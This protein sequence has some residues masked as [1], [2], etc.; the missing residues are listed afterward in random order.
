MTQTS[1][2]SRKK[3]SEDRGDSLRIAAIDVGS[4]SVHMIVA[5][6]DADGGVTTL[7]RMKEMVGLGRISFPSRRLSAEAM[8]RAVDTLSRFNQA[9]LQRGAERIVI[10]ATSA[11]REA[12]NGGDL[13]QRIRR[14]LKLYV[15][16]VTAR[17][18]ARLIYLGVRHAIDLGKQPTLLIDIGGGSVEFIVGNAV[19]ASLLESRKLGA[20]RITSRFVKSDPIDKSDRK[21]LRAH[22]HAELD[23]LFDQI[24][25]LKPVRVIGTS[26]TFENL[27]QLCGDTDDDGNPVVGRKSFSRV[28]KQL[29]ASD[30]SK[31]EKIPGLDSHR[32]EQIVAASLLIDFMMDE[33]KIDRIELA[34]AALREGILIDYL[35]RHMP[36]VQIRSEVSDPRRRSVIDLAR[37]CHWHEKHSIQVAHLT[38]RLFDQLHDLHRLGK[39]ERELIEYAALLHDIGWHIAPEG[40]HKHSMY[41]ILNSDLRKHFDAEELGIIANIARYHRKRPPTV[42]HES[43]ARLSKSGRRVVDVGAA[44][45]RVA[46]GMDRSHTSV[47]LDLKT[48]IDDDDGVVCR[49]DVRADAELEMWGAKR[50]SGYFEE[51]F[52]RAIDFEMKA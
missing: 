14:E 7:W 44:L 12:F 32:K 19:D 21:A 40:H 49:M 35:S 4:N 28:L 17:D 46:D 37:R 52:G 11:V 39:D 9:A 25:S 33:L 15:K 2:A 13:I 31:R 26:G 3:S 16:V 5:Q 24:R 6:I 1:A 27:A 50:K 51:L 47:V 30:A 23:G 36:D 43:Y 34:K 38:L 18:E 45:L 41:L 42:E 48:R 29:L 10:A 22:F 8:D 20:A